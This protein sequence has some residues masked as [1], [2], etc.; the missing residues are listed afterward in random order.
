MIRSIFC[1]GIIC[2]LTTSI[3]A[4]AVTSRC[5]ATGDDCARWSTSSF[6]TSAAGDGGVYIGNDGDKNRLGFRFP[7]VVV[8][9]G[10][11]IDSA[12]IKF[13]AQS[14]RSGS[15]VNVSLMA[16]PGDNMLTFFSM[17]YNQF[18][19]LSKGADSVVWS[20][21]PA[22]TSG[23]DYETFNIKSLIQ[24]IINRAGFKSGNAIG[25][26]V[27]DNGSTPNSGF[28]YA[29]SWDASP[30]T[31]ALLEIWYGSGSVLTA[32]TLAAPVDGSTGQPL[33][34]TLSWHVVSGATSYRV[35][36]STS[37]SFVTTLIDSPGITDS[38]VTLS[39]LSNSV[40]YYWHVSASGAA[41]T[42]AFSATN[43][44]IT[45]PAFTSGMLPLSVSAGGRYLQA[46]ATPVFLNADAPWSL[47][48]QLSY[49]QANTYLTDRASRGFNGVL[50]NLIEHHFCDH[51]PNNFYNVKPFTGTVF[52]T[53]NEPYFAL[54]DSMISR[55]SQLGIY[56]FL[57]PIY[58]GS[59]PSQGWQ[60]EASAAS[61]A[62]LK[63][64]GSYVGN[65]YKNY[66]NVV[67]VIG[68][69]MN[70]T[71][72]SG[73]RDKIDSMVAGMKAADNVYPGRLYTTHSER[74]TQAITH[75]PENWVS[76]NN[77][78]TSSST[79]ATFA[80]AAYAHSPTLP[81]FMIE[82]D[83]ENEGPT[84]QQL[85]AQAYW[86]IL[87]GGCGNIFGNCPIW[88]GGTTVYNCG[89]GT[90][91]SVVQN[92]LGSPGSVSM[93]QFNNLFTS[94]HWYKLVP[95]LNGT[96]LTSGAQTGTALATVA[97]ATDSTVILGYLPT[98]RSVTINPAR[99]KGDSIKVSWLNPGSGVF[100][101]AGSFS[102]I[103]RSYTPPASGDWVLVLDSGAT[104]VIVA[105]P[106]APTLSSPA[107]G[108]AG[109][110]SS[111]TLSWNTSAG[112]TSYRVQVSTDSAFGTSVLDQ[113]GIATTSLTA[114]GLAANTRYF[115]RVNA[116]N[117]GGSSVYSA[118]WT[119]TTAATILA[120]PV[121]GSPAN[122]ATGV[123]VAPSLT[124]NAS[125]GATSYRAQVSVD[126]A[127]GTTL[128][129][130]SGIAA[131]TLSIAGLAN[132]TIYYWRVNA[133][134]GAGTSNFSAIWSFTTVAASSGGGSQVSFRTLGTSTTSRLVTR[135]NTFMAY[136]LCDS[137]GSLDSLAVS[138]HNNWD[139]NDT[140][141]GIIYTGTAG[142]IGAYVARSR[143][144]VIVNSANFTPYIFHFNAGV[145][146]LSMA[147][148]YYIGVHSMTS[149]G[150][151]R[152]A[153][154]NNT[155][156][157]T[158][159]APD[160]PPPDNPWGL[161]EYT[162]Q[163]QLVVVAYGHTAGTGF[164]AG[165]A[166]PALTSPSN[167]ATNQSTPLAL[168]WSASN[169]ATSYHVQVSTD[170]AFGTIVI[171]QGGVTETSL[172]AGSLAKNTTYYWR[173][174]AANSGDNSQFSGGRQFTTGR[175]SGA[176]AEDTTAGNNSASNNLMPREFSL[177]QNYPNPFNP[178]TRI[179]FDL[180]NACAVTLEVFNT[181]GQRVRMLVNSQMAA[182][183]HTV[184]WNSTDA[185]GRAVSSG[186]Y[187]YRLTAGDRIVSRKMLLL[188]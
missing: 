9:Q 74:G 3:S 23:S 52:S 94:R 1:F 178:T 36:V 185:N 133:S 82:G 90:G 10:T 85:R 173:V 148:V 8:P 44:F 19:T 71:T 88:E 167:G 105:A 145:V 111:P 72:I 103:S 131:T 169:G 16:W 128:I 143:D 57:D 13:R 95:D 158:G 69:D 151:T 175:R 179:E 2:L 146:P 81:F 154:S 104:S 118:T 38:T 177:R 28:R 35:Q 129:D 70:V 58:L 59:D 112:A 108:S 172:T 170:S 42:S 116:S 6:Q 117:S 56:V 65:R 101:V 31:A 18:D 156:A 49:A 92:A 186:V 134:N 80:N 107:N 86:T 162:N 124:W 97:Y 24:P 163:N 181:L 76:L 136:A 113:S 75:W 11:S 78:Y 27:F 119:F 109:I 98:Q 120:A 184:D 130:Q 4:T 187:L 55:A 166:A 132:S 84:A 188:K 12:K 161:S 87:L 40:T 63:G 139:G 165:L 153:T 147:T 152:V 50:T 67:W 14:S 123:A 73:L 17:A 61:A 115:W 30:A 171:D 20:G 182:G 100:T 32:P 51:A 122:G 41:G 93:T 127:F 45:Q 102:K 43:N 125:S 110:S 66:P 68:A 7:N 46:G 114:S 155:T 83:Y 99:L 77:I 141:Y 176:S 121:L 138:M 159:Y 183:S 89:Q 39:G 29:N 106:S 150:Y 91:F 15:G 25:I 79:V 37:S 21:L 34:P 157:R 160:A 62:T 137:A 33:T 140:L 54:A 47:I 48:S 126:A 168:T 22:W 149:S 174:H 96:I 142:K 26:F 144:S 64:W 53:P 135:G 164:V 5:A 60:T 180:P